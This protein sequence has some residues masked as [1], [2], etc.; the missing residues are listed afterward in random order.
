MEI[1]PAIDILGGKVVRLAKG[2]YNAVT[3]Y[4]DNPLDQAFAFKDQGASWVHIVD[5]DGA[6]Q[7]SPVNQGIIKEIIT[8][9][10]LKVE[11]GGG[12]RSL[13]TMGTLADL[14]VSRM[15]IGTKLITD[16]DFAQMAVER[17]GDLICAGVDALD[18]M[19][20]IEG[21]RQDS[22]ISASE[23]VK[24][25]GDWGICHLVYTDISRD[26]M[27]T[28]IDSAAYVRIAR[29]AGFAVIASGGISTLDDLRNLGDLGEEM[30]EGA[31]IGRALYEGS[32]TVKQA[33]S[34]AR[35]MC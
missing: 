16:S 11:T 1:L 12:I 24:E 10:G 15:V 18:G 29:S 6:R 28:G 3:V 25:L 22:G 9:T 21:W 20:A 7:G 31:I 23:L 4:E 34:M 27:Q 33:V 17:F 35:T 5:L 14:G 19:V 30:I 8:A 26:G 13:D 32:F 2:D